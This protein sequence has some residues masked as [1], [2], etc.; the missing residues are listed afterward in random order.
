ML[1]G[2]YL[3]W[4]SILTYNPRIDLDT[5]SAADIRGARRA[6]AARPTHLA[7]DTGIFNVNVQ[8]GAAL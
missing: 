8:L 3:L 4:T 7:A 6:W 5:G 2:E 1:S